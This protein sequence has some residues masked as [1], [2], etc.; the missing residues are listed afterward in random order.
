MSG[1]GLESLSLSPVSFQWLQ[2]SNFRLTP[3]PV[4]SD[5][6]R[7][8]LLGQK[9]PTTLLKSKKNEKYQ[10]PESEV[11]E[12]VNFFDLQLRCTHEN[13]TV[14]TRVR[15]SGLWSRSPCQHRAKHVSP[16]YIFMNTWKITVNT[17]HIVIKRENI[18]LVVEK[19]LSWVTSALLAL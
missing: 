6:N 7:K 4:K 12:T 19:L 17:V 10:N 11:W 13:S 3:A 8:V 14:Y 16:L 1:T 15:G 9:N 18:S 2:C 5:S